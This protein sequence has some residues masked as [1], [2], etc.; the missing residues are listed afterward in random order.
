MD[1]GEYFLEISYF[2]EEKA[3][4]KKKDKVP[5]HPEIHFLMK[6][7][8]TP[9]YLE[10]EN[11]TEEQQKILDVLEELYKK[12]DLDEEIQPT[13]GCF[14]KQ[15]GE[16]IS[17]WYKLFEKLNFR[18]V[19]EYETMDW[20]IQKAYSSECY[21]KQLRKVIPSLFRHA[22]FWWSAR[23]YY[24]SRC[25]IWPQK[26]LGEAEIINNM[27]FCF[28]TNSNFVN[29]LYDLE[30]KER[31]EMHSQ[32]IKSLGSCI[33]KEWYE[34]HFSEDEIM[35]FIVYTMLHLCGLDIGEFIG[36]EDENDWDLVHSY[37]D[38]DS[39]MEESDLE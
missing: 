23:D 32:N 21:I 16:E 2:Q 14:E 25:Y 26:Y 1:L 17:Q 7:M 30:K 3:D 10:F 37:S 29:H 12:I 24:F 20:L 35:Q 13:R 6:I 9:E 15:M 33:L 4:D 8:N 34:D 18:G 36:D 22:M 19:A 28:D 27:V 39:E 5:F 38:S 11:N 31:D